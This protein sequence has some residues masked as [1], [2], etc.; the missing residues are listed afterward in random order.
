[1][2]NLFLGALWNVECVEGTR[3]AKMSVF[4][5]FCSRWDKR[6]QM[7]GPGLWKIFCS[8]EGHKIAR[9]SRQIIFR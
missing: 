4:G 7:R 1:M 6:R 8:P 5:V 2:W 9:Q 3:F